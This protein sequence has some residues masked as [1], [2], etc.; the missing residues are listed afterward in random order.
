MEV[1]YS[2]GN[3]EEEAIKIGLVIRD[4]LQRQIPSKKALYQ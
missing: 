4:D 3:N 2:N 1:P